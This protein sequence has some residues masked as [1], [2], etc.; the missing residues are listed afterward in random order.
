MDS[1]ILDQADFLAE[2]SLVF[3]NLNSRSRSA[4]LGIASTALKFSSFMMDKEEEIL[5]SW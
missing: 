3:E 5:S 1:F 2:T 4:I